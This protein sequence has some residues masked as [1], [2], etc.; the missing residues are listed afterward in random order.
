MRKE[1]DWTDCHDPLSLGF[2]N[3]AL[4]DNDMFA[5]CLCN[6]QKNVDGY[7]GSVSVPHAI[8]LSPLLAAPTHHLEPARESTR[9]RL[10]AL[11][12]KTN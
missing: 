8:R 9:V 11:E 5:R 4:E 3:E 1:V 7:E 2:L 6:I 10:G 12:C